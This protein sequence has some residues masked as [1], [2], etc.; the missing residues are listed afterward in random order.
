MCGIAGIIHYKNNTENDISFLNECIKTMHH[1]GPDSNGIW[2]NDK[3]YS[4]AFVRLAIRDLS[5]NGNQPMHSSCGRYVITFN[6]EIYNTNDFKQTLIND[7]IKF[8]STT[9][10]EVLLYALIKWG[11]NIIEKI[12]GIFAFAL[13]DKQEN[14]LLLCRDRLGIK[15]LYIGANSNGLIYSSQYN[16]IINHT[17]FNNNG[18][19]VKALH[20]Y[21][22]FGYVPEGEGL[23]KETFLL[24]HGHYI[25]VKNNQYTIKKYY[26]Y[27]V[28]T[29]S[30]TFDIENIVQ[31]CVKQQLVSDVPL[32]TFM[33]GGVDSTL[34]TY[35]ATKVGDVQ[36]FTIG[37]D[38]AHLNESDTAEQFAH[39]FKTK[40][41]T[42]LITENTL[43]HT[44]QD[45][46]AAFSEPFADPSSIPTMVLSKFVRNK[47]TVALSGDG[48]DELFWGYPRN[49]TVLADN[50]LL[51]KNKLFLSAKYL[52]EKLLNRERT[53]AQ[54]HLQS[55]GLIDYYYKRLFIA[56]ASVY[57]KDILKDFTIPKP[58][59]VK[60]ML[61][62]T[63]DF[64]NNVEA[65]NIIRKLEV[66]L[67]LQRILIKV[68]RASMFHSLEVRVPLLD[69]DMIDF[70]TAMT[71]KEC[72]INNTGKVNL[73]KLLASK[74][75][76][77]LVYKPK[78]GF[79]IPMNKW[80]KETLYKEVEEKLYN[81]PTEL[82]IYFKES[83]IKK[84]LQE[85]KT[86]IREHT[87]LIWALYTL[88]LWYTTHFNKKSKL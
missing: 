76:D 56:G 42:E 4:T 69:N 72:L 64:N 85:H 31:K 19:D 47:V 17:Y 36:S 5:A 12:N 62:N 67:H 37:V 71:F 44:I 24:Q 16:H 57:A 22:C 33:S 10:T 53:I 34:V 9:D 3:N 70:S 32:G 82:K 86:G 66:D 45:N 18:I 13:Y 58:Y 8:K 40:H 39:L 6:G 61:Q 52:T 20:G 2:S 60:E 30:T 59:F 79:D 25:V 54:R 63:F 48:G 35:A 51:Q 1:R 7:G 75:N 23:I 73:K 55:N 80:L 74:T 46:I 77:D 87:W 14:T 15:P 65:M 83:G 29:H 49:R 43:L 68:D 41:H 81:L 50:A 28:T 26:D 27:P 78:K 11:E 38:D 88:T 21:F 84:I